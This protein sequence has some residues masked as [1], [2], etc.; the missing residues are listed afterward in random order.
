LCVVC[1]CVYLS[2]VCVCLFDFET[3]TIFERGTSEPEFRRFPL[4]DK[5][6]NLKRKRKKNEWMKKNMNELKETNTNKQN[7]QT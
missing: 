1:V 4:F 6:G 2:D 3:Y 7:K 5:N